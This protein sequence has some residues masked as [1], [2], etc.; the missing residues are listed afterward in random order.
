[1]IDFLSI[2]TKLSNWWNKCIRIKWLYITPYSLTNL[3]YSTYVSTLE[4]L[5]KNRTLEMLDVWF[6]GLLNY[7]STNMVFCLDGFV[8]VSKNRVSGVLPVHT[9][10]GYTTWLEH[11]HRQASWSRASVIYKKYPLPLETTWK[12]PFLPK[13]RHQS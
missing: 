5:L 10:S 12:A 1:M 11:K 8:R 6:W 7:S 9:Y 2:P 13:Y 3:E 4:D